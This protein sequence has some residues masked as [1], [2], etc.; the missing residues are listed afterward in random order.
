MGND[1][2]RWL[3]DSIEGKGELR[4]AIEIL[5]EDLSH[6]LTYHSATANEA[7]WQ[8]GLLSL[9]GGEMIVPVLP[10]VYGVGVCPECGRWEPYWT[11]MDRFVE[12]Y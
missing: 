8:H 7:V 11:W 3:Q 5:A 1:V 9:I 6:Q 12:D 4:K 2:D 10:L